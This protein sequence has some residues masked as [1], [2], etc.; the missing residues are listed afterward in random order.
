MYESRTSDY[1]HA[2]VPAELASRVAYMPFMVSVLDIVEVAEATSQP[3]ERSPVH[4]HD[5]RTH[6]RHAR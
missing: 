1:E 3:L 6:G 4:D 5:S 2:G